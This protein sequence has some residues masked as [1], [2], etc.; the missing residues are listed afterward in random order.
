[1]ATVDVLVLD[2]N[3]AVVG[4]AWVMLDAVPQP[5]ELSGIT[6]FSNV[7]RTATS[8]TIEVDAPF[9]TI[10]TAEFHGSLDTGEW[11]NA[12]LSRT[13]I[14]DRVLLTMRLGRLD[15]APN[16]GKKTE[17]EIRDM[18]AR[19]VDARGVV[20]EV[21]KITPAGSPGPWTT[22]IGQQREPQGVYLTDGIVL[23]PAK[24]APDK[25]S[26]FKF[27]GHVASPPVDPLNEGRLFW[28]VNGGS[29]RTKGG[30]QTPKFA[31]AVWARNHD[32][33]TPVDALDMIV[34]FTPTTGG[35]AAR[36]PFGM[37]LNTGPPP[38]AMQQFMDLG[39]RY[40]FS[41]MGSVHQ[42]VGRGRKAVIVMPMNRYGDR[43]PYVY[44][45]GLFRLCREVALLLHRECQTSSLGRDS[46]N[47]VPDAQRHSGGSLRDINLPGIFATDFGVAPQLGRVAVAG[48]SEGIACVKQVMSPA[49][50]SL[51]AAQKLPQRYWGSVGG[52]AADMLGED[53][54]QAQWQRCF[55]EIWDLDGYHDETGG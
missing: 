30:G 14:D 36:Y 53:G 34:Y 19:N 41:R 52:V 7:S 3:N 27:N 49:R 6:T 37:W 38:V 1:M 39:V 25:K 28:L 31:V 26:W 15:V 23:A 21:L 17:A 29:S 42:L 4:D 2:A 35:W 51:P 44:G 18:S 13:V 48:F 46:P 5:V 32:T 9:Y 54:P 50:W 8:H 24:P 20:L 22:Y 55:R 40:M 45:E 43:G 16:A 33:A 47:R 10:E 11:N 12:L